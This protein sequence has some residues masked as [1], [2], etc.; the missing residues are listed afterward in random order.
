MTEAQWVAAVLRLAAVVGV[1][2]GVI[3]WLSERVG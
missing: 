1:G 3:M 2:G